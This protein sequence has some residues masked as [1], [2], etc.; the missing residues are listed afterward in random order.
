M[1]KREKHRHNLRKREASDTF[2]NTSRWRKLRKM[3]IQQNPLCVWCVEEG[4][5][6]AGDVV[7]HI[8]P[9]K[10]GGSETD[11][12]NLQTMCHH[13]H[14][15]KSAWESKRNRKTKDNEKEK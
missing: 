3:F 5:T 15:Q 14:N 7:D 1:G 2:Y 12:N 11:W 8:T 6:M 13:H 9:I 4:K 10:E